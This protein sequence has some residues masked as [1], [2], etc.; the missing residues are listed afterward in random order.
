MFAAIHGYDGFD[1]TA[2]DRP[3]AWPQAREV[4]SFRVGYVEG[5]RSLDERPEI[6][7]L[8]QSGVTLAPI[9]LPADYPIDK[10]NLI[11]DTE[12]AAVFDT[13]TREGIRE[14]IGHWQRRSDA[15]NLCRRLNIY[16]RQI[17]C[18]RLSCG[19]WKTRCGISMPTSAGTILRSPISLATRPSLCRT[20]C[21]DRARPNSRAR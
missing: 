8:R 10:L 20:V 14:G 1:F 15:A 12:A 21:D 17:E 7:K 18:A 3:F 16:R 11:L 9:K 5:R 6:S 4:K 2:V 19:K 13:L